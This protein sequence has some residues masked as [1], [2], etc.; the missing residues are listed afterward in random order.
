MRPHFGL[1]AFHPKYTLS[2]SLARATEHPIDKRTRELQMRRPAASL[3]AYG[4]PT[5]THYA[6]SLIDGHEA[7]LFWTPN[8]RH[9]STYH[10]MSILDELWI[11][12]T[13]MSTPCAGLRAR[14]HIT[15]PHE[16]PFLLQCRAESSL[17]SALVCFGAG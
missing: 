14:I 11:F 13:Q 16:S 2:I 8:F 17:C 3:W 6:R 9:A 5:W 7:I 4:P 1:T 10:A 12:S 15:R